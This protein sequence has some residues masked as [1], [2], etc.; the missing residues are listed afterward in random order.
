[1]GMMTGI[2]MTAPERKTMAETEMYT[3]HIEIHNRRTTPEVADS[4]GK[5]KQPA[6]DVRTEVI[7]IT[8]RQP[9]LGL[10][11]HVAED[12]LATYLRTTSP[13]ASVRS[14]VGN[15]GTIPVESKRTLGLND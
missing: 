14:T 15:T 13:S 10:A 3:V 11:V 5:L 12:Y 9:T 2:A 8:V 7:N 4:Y 6:T 1:M